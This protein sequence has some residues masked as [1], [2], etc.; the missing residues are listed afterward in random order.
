MLS[1]NLLLAVSSM[2]ALEASAFWRLPCQDRLVLERIDPIE[3]PGKFASHVHTVHG[4]QS[5]SCC[6]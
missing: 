6:Y 1:R 5:M 3:S 2:F 4:A